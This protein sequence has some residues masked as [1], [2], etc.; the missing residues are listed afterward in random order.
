MITSSK[1]F[2]RGFLVLCFLPLYSMEIIIIPN[3]ETKE[4]AET[5]K[6]KEKTKQLIIKYQL[7]K[8]SLPYLVQLLSLNRNELLEKIT[9]E[10][11]KNETLFKQYT[12]LLNQKTPIEY[13]DKKELKIIRLMIRAL[14]LTSTEQDDIE[15]NKKLFTQ[16]SLQ[17]HPDKVANNLNH[18]DQS[19]WEPLKLDYQE[20]CKEYQ[21]LLKNNDPDICYKIIESIDQKRN[22]I[23]KKRNEIIEQINNPPALTCAAH[24]FCST[25]LPTIGQGLGIALCNKTFA[26]LMTRSA[27]ENDAH[28]ACVIAART[29][30]LDIETKLVK[31]SRHPQ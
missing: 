6:L 12:Q 13:N 18:I 8:K 9:N 31:L 25:A 27:G 11:T 10:N 28:K 22:D 17:Y 30:A 7:I 26:K 21:S 5:K 14:Y 24:F 15:A 3:A 2:I 20:F 19:L 29:T 4:L 23:I 16:I 1:F